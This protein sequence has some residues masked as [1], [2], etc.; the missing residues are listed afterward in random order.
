MSLSWTAFASV[1]AL[2]YLVPGPDFLLVLHWST[3]SRLHGL[4]AGLGAQTGLT[5]HVA[6]AVVGLTAVL[7][8]WPPGL[9]TIRMAGATYLVWLGLRLATTRGEAVDPVR[10]RGRAPSWVAA[11]QALG[12][13][14]LN[15]KAIIFITSVLP[16]FAHGRWPVSAQLLVLGAIDVVAGL[17][18]WALVA[19]AGDRI[20]RWLQ[21]PVVDQRWRRANGT[22]LVV[23]AVSLLLTA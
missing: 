20:S 22:L 11:R 18:V 13:N 17:L 1:L 19:T 14:L 15:P 10:S 2:A 16:Q 3:R 23:L 7:T 6:L 8:A 5:V 12:T 21:D 9:T 4:A